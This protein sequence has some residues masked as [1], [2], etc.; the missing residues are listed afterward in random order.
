MNPLPLL[1]RAAM[2]ATSLHGLSEQ[3]FYLAAVGLRSDGAVVQTTNK[4]VRAR[5]PRGTVPARILA[6]HAESRLCRK[7]DAG[8]TVFVARIDR[9]GQWAMA[10]PCWVC[11]AKMKARRV[12]T[13][14]YTIGPGDEYGQ[15]NL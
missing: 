7:L 6:S 1:R 13:V 14:F 15:F 12:E 8:A 3:E 9:M 2:L 5:T 11:R 4:A 10:S